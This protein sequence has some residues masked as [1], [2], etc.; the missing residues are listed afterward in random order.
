MINYNVKDIAL[1]RKKTHGFEEYRLAMS[2]NSVI[3]SDAANNLSMVDTASFFVSSST[4]LSSSYASTASYLVGGQSLSSSWASQSL[5]SSYSY[6]SE[7]SIS[8]SYAPFTQEVQTSASWASQSLSSSYSYLSEQSISAS[9]APF[10]Q[11]VQTSASWA[12]QSLSS[13]YSY[14]SE[15]SISASYAPFIQEVQVSSSW[16]SQS[17][18]S[19]YSQTATLTVTSSYST[20]AEVAYSVNFVPVTAISASWIS[21]SAIGTPAAANSASYASASTVASSINFVPT[22]TISASWVSASTHIITADT[23]SYISPLLVGTP[24][25]ATSASFASASAVAYSINFVPVSAASASWISASAIGTPSSATSASYASASVSASYV[26]GSNSVLGTLLL[27]P[28]PSSSALVISQSLPISQSFPPIINMVSVWSGSSSQVFTGIKYNVIDS[29][30]ASTSSLIDLQ[31]QGLSKFRVDKLGNVYVSPSSTILSTGN[32]LSVGSNLQLFF[33][34]GGSNYY[35]VNTSG[36]FPGV[37]G[38]T[39]GDITRP[40]RELWLG[41]GPSLASGPTVLTSDATSSLALRNGGTLSVPAS[42]SFRIYNFYSSSGADFERANHYWSGSTYYIATEYS[43]SG[44]PRNI[45]FQTSGS[46][47]ML[48]TSSGSVL[49]GSGSIPN[50]T[51]PFQVHVSNTS[52]SFWVDTSGHS[53]MSQGRRFYVDGTGALSCIYY[54]NSNLIFQQNGNTD[55]MS[56]D[57]SG[58]LWLGTNVVAGTPFNKLNVQG[59]ISCSVIT[60]SAYS[61][62]TSSITPANSSSIAAWLPVFANGQTF[63]MPLYQ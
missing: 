35:T 37:A 28:S 8:A 4:T 61:S 25:A 13:S 45:V 58:S 19:S 27:S 16:A 39:L 36:I 52:P 34:L 55:M 40:Y 63:Y 1:Q 44:Q 50:T 15:Q 14:L 62:I 6:L 18:S 60:A 17:L 2:P 46:N 57:K 54:T 7:Q 3:V 24:A 47:R 49:V 42:Q 29:G 33:S 32:N 30:S 22:N 51:N 43:G 31:S 41:S 26:S 48:I 23:A 10:I 53:R 12:S 11:E 20:N 38:L 21:A 59:N 56:L 9:Y 5:S